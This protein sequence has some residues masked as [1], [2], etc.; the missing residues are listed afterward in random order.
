MSIDEIHIEGLAK[1]YVTDNTRPEMSFSLSS[2]KPDT[3][4]AR[5]SLRMSDWQKENI[6]SQTGIVIDAPSWSPFTKYEIHLP[7]TDNHGQTTERKRPS[8]M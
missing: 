1:D 2:D 4:L 3:T 7:V 5:A 8:P 6:Q